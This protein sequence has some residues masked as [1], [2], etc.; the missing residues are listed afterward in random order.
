MLREWAEILLP[1]LLPTTLY[2]GWVWMARWAGGAATP[3]RWTAMPWLWLAGA[4]VVLLALFL[5]VATIG[6]GSADEGVYVPPRWTGSRIV[7]GHFE[8]ARKANN[9]RPAARLR[10]GD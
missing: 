8:P 10:L 9:P 5:V 7:P 1:L 3:V 6:F 2:F 4:G